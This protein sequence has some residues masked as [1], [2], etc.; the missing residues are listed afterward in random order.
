MIDFGSSCY[1]N[2]RVYTYIQ[3]RFYRAPE[4]I[5]GARYS[6]AIDMW[7]FG[8]I[9][10]ELLTGYPLFAGEDE[11]DQLA[12]I[13]EMFGVPPAHLLDSAKR[14]RHFINF[15]GYP[16]YCTVN[17]GPDGSVELAGGRS[18]RG[19]YRGPPGTKDLATDA[20]R[21]CDDRAFID[22]LRCCLDLN[23]QSRM[24]PA[25]AMRHP[26]LSSR[27]NSRQQQQQLQSN[28][29]YEDTTTHGRLSRPLQTTTTTTTT[30]SGRH[31]RANNNN[32][33]VSHSKLPQI[34]GTM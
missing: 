6:T 34:I 2:Q 7:S 14:T 3:S 30:T 1:E 15:Q 32:A 23:P 27:R 4:V 21:D 25:E 16:R 31:L 17:T 20:L 24:T 29:H 33:V 28:S 10:S 13:I 9:L 12:C 18:R 8:C 11:A 19:K 22:F 26:W 5:V